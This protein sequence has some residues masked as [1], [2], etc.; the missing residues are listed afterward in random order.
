MPFKVR[1]AGISLDGNRYRTRLVR[2]CL[3]LVS[4]ES[5][6]FFAGDSFDY[7]LVCVTIDQKLAL[8]YFAMATP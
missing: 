5:K 4:F 6:D 8:A 7:F 1:T 3:A 2:L